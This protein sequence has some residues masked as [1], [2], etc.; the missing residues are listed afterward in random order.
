MSLF[1]SFSVFDFSEGLPYVSITKNGVT[2]NKGV[3]MK[4]QY[5]QHVI[6]LISQET[7][8]IAIKTCDETTPKAVAFYKKDK[9]NDASKILSVRWNAKDLMANIITMTGWD[10]QENSY[11]VLG[12][13]VKEESA[14][15]FD[16][17]KAEKTE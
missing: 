2:F 16:F 1:D 14:M 11:R 9:E 6:L 12:E 7:H 3:M 15:L 10:L 17:D 13:L 8:Q 4:M 5:P